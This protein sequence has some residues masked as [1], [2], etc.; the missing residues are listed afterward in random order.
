MRRCSTLDDAA[1]LNGVSADQLR[2]WTERGRTERA[3]IHREFVL[4]V[5]IA[6]AEVKERLLALVVDAS[7][8]DPK[9]ATWLLSKRWPR[10]YGDQVRHV[11]ESEMELFL[12]AAERVLSRSDYERLLSEI[13]ARRSGAA[14]IKAVDGIRELPE[15]ST[16]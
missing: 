5:E 1:R 15:P 8:T 11:I 2:E 9:L 3:G 14:T 6:Q 13:T 16:P 4:A 10:E 12:D 7:A